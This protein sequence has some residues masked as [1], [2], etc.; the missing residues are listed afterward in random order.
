MMIPFFLC[1]PIYAITQ[2]VAVVRLPGGWRW[3]SLAPALPMIFVLA[4]TINACGE[5]IDVGPLLLFSSPM[6]MV[7]VLVIVA[8]YEPSGEI[9]SK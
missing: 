1:F 4:A 3:V 2:I 7:Y 8:L 6:A 5:Q 9:Q